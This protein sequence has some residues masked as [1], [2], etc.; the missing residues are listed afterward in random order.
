[1]DSNIYYL[2]LLERPFEAIRRGTKTVEVRANKDSVNR[3][4]A[5]DTIIF[6]KCGTNDKLKCTIVRIT[7]YLTVRDLLVTEGI[8]RTL[9]SGKDLEDGIKSIESISDYKEQIARNGVLAIV[10]K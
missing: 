1:M 9:S 7:L 2:N 8:E 3:M 10:L 6:T 5:D 4:K